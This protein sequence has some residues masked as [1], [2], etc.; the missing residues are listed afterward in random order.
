MVITKTI[1]TENETEQF[2]YGIKGMCGKSEYFFDDISTDR[3][4]AEIIDKILL[5][6]ELPK[7]LISRIVSSLVGILTEKT[8]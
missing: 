4:N 8:V 6:V 3:E 5:A 2:T 7:N 1:K